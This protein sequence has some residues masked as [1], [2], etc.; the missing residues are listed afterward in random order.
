MIYI[1]EKYQN[2]FSD[3]CH[4]YRTK[5]SRITSYDIFSKVYKKNRLEWKVLY[6]ITNPILV[7]IL[8]YFFDKSAFIKEYIK[9]FLSLR[10]SKK[11]GEKKSLIFKKET[12]HQH[13]YTIS[14]NNYKKYNWSY[15]I[16]PRWFAVYPY[17]KMI[18]HKLKEINHKSY[19]AC[20]LENEMVSSKHIYFKIRKHAFMFYL[21]YIKKFMFF[22][23]MRTTGYEHGS[24]EKLLK[25]LIGKWGNY[26]DVKINYR[27]YYDDDDDDYYKIADWLNENNIQFY[28]DYLDQIWYFSKSADAVYFKMMRLK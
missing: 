11:D 15:V 1:R 18:R 13:N 14:R 21:W 2:L 8:I 3:P 28:F 26:I 16:L 20:E 12:D 6:T 4:Q 24:K 22:W 25:H 5:N 17:N 19:S 10:L 23:M 9:I 27:V 7:K